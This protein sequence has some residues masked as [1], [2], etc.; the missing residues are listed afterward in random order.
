MKSETLELQKQIMALQSRVE[1]LE[2]R[3][4]SIPNAVA[5]NLL[6]TG[7]MNFP[8]ITGIWGGH[9]NRAANT[10]PNMLPP[11]LPLTNSNASRSV[12][13]S[14][15]LPVWHFTPN[16]FLT[17]GT[18]AALE[19]QGGE[20]GSA[21]DGFTIGGWF[22][23]DNAGSWGSGN[24]GLITKWG[25]S[26]Q[27]SYLLEITS[28]K[29]ARL[30]VSSTG[31]NVNYVEIPTALDYSKWY[32]ICG[33]WRQNSGNVEIFVNGSSDTDTGFSSIFNST[34]PFRVGQYNSGA[35][36]DGRMAGVFAGGLYT[37]ERQINNYY[38]A[39]KNLFG[40]ALGTPP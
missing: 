26:G 37:F 5:N 31:A 28:S 21:E 39:T 16:D 38:R 11:S 32:F 3:D 34:T 36:Y 6:Y 17:L 10:M 1:E 25:A 22:F 8:G 2:V 12:S 4:P 40:A 30:S 33:S 35:Y 13:S 7:W 15:P 29:Y 19:F 18:T 23:H 24:I 27:Y 14:P 20:A 9:Y